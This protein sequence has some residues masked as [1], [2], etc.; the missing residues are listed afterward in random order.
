M[1]YINIRV[2]KHKITPE[3][4][5]ARNEPS[6][7]KAPIYNKGRHSF[8]WREVGV[9]GAG[10]DMR[11]DTYDR[12]DSGVVDNAEALIGSSLTQI[13]DH[14]PKGH[15]NTQHIYSFLATC[16]KYTK[17]FMDLLGTDATGLEDYDLA[18]VRT[19]VPLTHSNDYHNEPLLTTC[20]KY[21]KTLMGLLD[22]DVATLDGKSPGVGID[23][24]AFYDANGRVADVTKVKGTTVDATDIGAGKLLAYDAT[25]EALVYKTL[26]ELAPALTAAGK[27]ILTGSDQIGTKTSDLGELWDK[28]TKLVTG[29]FEATE[30]DQPNKIPTLD[31]STFLALSQVVGNVPGLSGTGKLILTQAGTKVADLAALWNK[32]TEL[33]TS[34]FDAA[35]FNV[36]NGMVKLD[37]SAKVPYGTVPEVGCTA[38]FVVAASNSEN[39]D[40]ADYICTDTDDQGKIK[41]AIVDL[42]AGGGSI[43]LLEG[44]YTIDADDDPIVINA[45]NN[46]TL[47]GQGNGTKLCLGT[48]IV[49]N[50]IEVINASGVLIKDLHIDGTTSAASAGDDLKQC[51]IIFYTATDSKIKNVHSLSNKRHGIQIT[52]SS[53]RN[54]VINCT[55]K[56]NTYHGLWV[57][58]SSTYNILWRN[59]LI[60]NTVNG[61]SIYSN[62]DNNTI[63]GNIS[64]D[65]SAIGILITSANN[66]TI[67]GNTCNDSA[68]DGIQLADAEC[69]TITGNSCCNGGSAGIRCDSVTRYNTIFGNTTSNNLVGIYLPW[70]DNN[71]V[72]GNTCFNNNPNGGIYAIS[73]GLTIYGNTC[74][75]NTSYGITLLQYGQ[76]VVFGN[77]CCGNASTGALVYQNHKYNTVVGN[78]FGGNGGHGIFLYTVEYNT[79]V[80]NILQGNQTHGIDIYTSSNNT[81]SNNTSTKNSQV[82]DNLYDNL[83]IIE[84]SDYNNTQRNTCRAGSGAIAP[85]YGINVF[86]SNCTENFVTNNDIYNDNYGTGSL[87][88]AAGSG[89]VVTAGNRTA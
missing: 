5:A 26:A 46:I 9:V 10:G 8:E 84:N 2:K 66:N 78:T 41:E 47:Q 57:S 83:A 73:E 48:G 51:G 44:S 25:T 58:N 35:T 37:A 85:R 61:T 50:V 76:N 36:A 16:D 32:T 14:A 11:K 27:L 86:N 42:P 33:V 64:K 65:N 89:T 13:R 68:N 70:G 23:N 15:N 82:T 75:N 71:I 19:H 80:S 45:R 4:V 24:I 49:T 28:G 34:D 39:K 54:S 29:D 79:I 20:N 3:D 43:L 72:A 87:N 67:V 17:G 40:K 62:S 77:S 55:C 6:E 59:I 56:D 31:A 60:N 18:G 1:A 7:S 21:T 81:I 74:Y 63:I 12:T 88:I 69:N 30:F 53:Q 38:T 52:A 22:I